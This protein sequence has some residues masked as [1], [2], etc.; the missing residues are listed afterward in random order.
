MRCKEHTT[1][2]ASA[3]P[4]LIAFLHEITYDEAPVHV[5]SLVCQAQDMIL[6]RTD[7]M[8][9]IQPYPRVAHETLAIVIA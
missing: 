7:T 1:G 8:P 4:N 2:S 3:A 9:E 6:R 5:R